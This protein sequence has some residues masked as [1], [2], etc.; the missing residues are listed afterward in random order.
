[1][2]SNPNP[3]PAAPALARIEAHAVVLDD[4]QDVIGAALE[5][6][7]DVLRL[8]VL[9]D[10]GQ[11]LLRDAI[12]RRLGLGRQPIVEQSRRVQLGRRC[13]ARRPVLDVVGQRRAQAEIVERGRPELP[14]EMIDVA[15][16]RCATASS[17][18]PARAGRRGPRTRP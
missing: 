6:D 11:R 12:E 4:Q 17:A 1:M 16:E 18:R 7:L 14:D 3:W 5:D 10:V 15:I 2:P 9:G 8:R 13:R